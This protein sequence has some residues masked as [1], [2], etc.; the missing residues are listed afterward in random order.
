MVEVE[1]NYDLL[2]KV[3]NGL[4]RGIERRQIGRMK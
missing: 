1:F 3:K 4:K 2:K